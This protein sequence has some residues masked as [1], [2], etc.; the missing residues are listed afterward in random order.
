MFEV[1]V[2]SRNNLRLICANS[3]YTNLREN[4]YKA[5]LAYHALTGCDFTALFS[6]IGKIQPQKK[7]KKSVQAQIVFQ[8]LGELDDDQSKDL[9][10][11][12][13]FTCKM[14]GKKNLKKNRSF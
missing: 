2:Q 14:Y 6:W 11:V 13:I 3:I 9:T 4:L 8:H 1:G 10:E 7:L 5:L 12:E